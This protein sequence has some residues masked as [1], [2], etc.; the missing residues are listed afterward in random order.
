[1]AQ[2][3]I[4][5][6]DTLKMQGE[7]L[8]NVLGMSFSTA[9]SIFVSQAVREGGIPFHI[10]TNTDPFYSVSNMEVLMQ[11]IQAANEGK[12]TAHELIEN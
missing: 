4:R 10:T 8:F 12:L 9:F 5:I 6:D 3:N 7:K 2:I 1:M 11:S